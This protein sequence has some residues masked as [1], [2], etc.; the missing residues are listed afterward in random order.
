MISTLRTANPEINCVVLSDGYG[1]IGVSSY[2]SEN[3]IT[4]LT[5]IGIDDSKEALLAVKDGTINCTV[6]QDFYTMGYQSVYL[7][8]DVMDGNDYVYDNDSGSSILYAEDVDARAEE[9]GISLDE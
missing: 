6:V 3:T 1:T 4:D 5:V 9:I 8:K 2:V 7:C